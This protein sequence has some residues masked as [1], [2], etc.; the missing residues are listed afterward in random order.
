MVVTVLS[1]T[2]DWMRPWRASSA[3]LQFTDSSS[4]LYFTIC[5]RKDITVAFCKLHSDSVIVITAV[6]R[7]SVSWSHLQV[8]RFHCDHVFW[9]AEVIAVADCNL[10]ESLQLLFVNCLK[11]IVAAFASAW[12]HHNHRCNLRNPSQS[13]LATSKIHRDCSSVRLLIH[14]N[15]SCKIMGKGEHGCSW[16]S[17][18]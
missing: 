4:W 18:W 14:R 15:R 10:V 17:S 8:T 1:L 9:F 5:G 13:H 6:T 16:E 12:H 3:L 11:S 7:W 2:F